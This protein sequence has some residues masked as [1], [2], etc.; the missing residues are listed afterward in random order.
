MNNIL[1]QT[2]G[3]DVSMDT[4]VVRFGTT[5]T[6]QDQQISNSESF[7]NTKDGFNKFIKWTKNISSLMTS[8]CSL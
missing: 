6:N 3:I 5:D 1:K 7:K 2:F 4:F 8:H